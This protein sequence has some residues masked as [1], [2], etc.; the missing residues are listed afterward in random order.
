MSKYF[1][2]INPAAGGKKKGLVV[3]QIET[4][5]NNRNIDFE[6]LDR[7]ISKISGNLGLKCFGLLWF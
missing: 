4:T 5:L 3:Q 2:I 1:I 7:S 6:I